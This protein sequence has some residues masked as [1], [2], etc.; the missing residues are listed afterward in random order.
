MEP[1]R[2]KIRAVVVAFTTPVF[3]GA[4][5][6]HRGERSS[7]SLLARRLA[8][9]MSFDWW[10]ERRRRCRERSWAVAEA[11]LTRG[12]DGVLDSCSPR[13]EQR[14]ELRK[15][16]LSSGAS[17]HLHVVTAS[18][19]LRWQRV[20]SRHRGQPE[21]LALLVSED[22]FRG[23]RRLVGASYRGRAG[24]RHHIPRN[25]RGRRTLPAAAAPSG[26]RQVTRHRGRRDGSEAT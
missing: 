14:R 20:L 15:R 8:Q 3:A 25:R 2:S 17:V 26:G 10:A 13:V 11:A 16:A 22:M 1:S 18:A 7:P 21:T 4:S 6:G 24:S 5:R 19:E 12:L 23:R 9:P